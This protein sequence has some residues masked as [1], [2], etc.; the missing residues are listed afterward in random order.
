MNFFKSV[1]SDEPTPPDSPTSQPG[2]PTTLSQSQ[3]SNP[4]PSPTANPT[5]SFGGLFKTL[6]TTSESV[7][8]SY[9]KD[10]EEFG[11]GL[12]KETAVIREV[13]S[14]AVKDLPASFEVG[15]SVAQESLETVGQAIDDIGATVWRSTAQI[16]S[17]GRDSILAPDHED[18]DSSDKHHSHSKQQS[19]SV[20]RYSRF[21]M[22]VRAIQCDLNTYCTEPEDKVE[23]DRWRLGS[24][25]LEEKKEEIEKLISENGFVKEIYNEVVPDRVDNEGF[26][27]RYF[28]RVHK[29]KQAEETRALLVKKAISGEEEDLTWDFDGEDKE[30]DD[31]SNGSLVEGQSSGSLKPEKG[32]YSESSEGHNKNVKD[33]MEKG[34]DK[35]EKFEEKAAAVAVKGENGESCKDSDVSV[36]SSQSLL[37]EEDLGWD[38]IED[39]DESKGEKLGS[40]TSTSRLDL[41]KRLSA[42]EEEEDLSW[43][44]DDEDDEPSKP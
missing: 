22:Q 13:A 35:L 14:R 17:H 11:S 8:E 19:L 24:F 20:K 2:T 6:T 34:N 9:R 3:S 33:E 12:R 16:I 15:A 1:F 25:S 26:W 44:I 21:D 4:N 36:I 28:Y 7:I 23:F 32:D 10:F 30:G 18:S 41:R 42:A 38:E 29:L 40:S 43:D 37:P 39:I 27:S 31:K 5:W